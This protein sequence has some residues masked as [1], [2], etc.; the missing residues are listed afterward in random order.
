MTQNPEDG[1]LLDKV[2]RELRTTEVSRFPNP[3][4][5]FSESV[6]NRASKF[7]SGWWG[8]L[9]AHRTF[10]VAASVLLAMTILIAQSHSPTAM[11]QVQD[12]VR[13]ANAISFEMRTLL[14][15][16]VVDKHQ[17]LFSAGQGVRSESDKSLYVFNSESK[18]ML[19]VNHIEKSAVIS[20]VL[21]ADAL[22]RQVGGAIGRLSSLEPI[23]QTMVRHVIRDGKQVSELW[24]V[25]DGAVVMVTVD[26]ESSLPIH[27][28]I[29]RGRDTD[30]R[31]IREEIDNLQFGADCEK[32]E[33]AIHAPDSYRV[34]TIPALEDDNSVQ[35]VLSDNGLGRVTWGMSRD[36]VIARLGKPDAV[37][38]MPG[39]EPVMKDGKPVLIPGIGAGI[40]MVP[41][42]PPFERV[43]FQYDSRGFRIHLSSK[44]GV[45]SVHCFDARMAS[46]SCRRFDGQSAEG[47]R[48]G[49]TKAQV[50]DR[51][52]GRELPL[53]RFNF[54]E[55]RL[56]AM[57][58]SYSRQ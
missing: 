32:M 18:E 19:E 43:T 27:V 37:T 50:V 52:G 12:S 10:A 28:E 36:A 42:N 4:V 30:G 41:A 40:K 9:Y 5:V 7:Y 20:P 49:M 47:I 15:G 3:P 8:R 11:A 2:V 39:M 58:S 25:W 38:T 1:A 23:E 6:S 51:L 54:R 48:I 33:F 56:V 14:D 55:D 53:G 24:S 17:V 21:D 26:L 13:N 57:S 22:Q 16:S 31:W 45:E 44:F 35:L 29:D 46:T 34:Q